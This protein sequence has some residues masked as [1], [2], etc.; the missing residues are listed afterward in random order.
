MDEN[1]LPPDA[2]LLARGIARLLADLG[3]GSLTEFTL[4]TGRRMDLM[5]LDRRGRL[6]GVEIKRSLQD[7]RADRK[8]PEYL[9]YCDGFYFAVPP[10]FPVEVLPGE[11]GLILADAWGAEIVRP[12]PEPAGRIAP[13]RRRELTLRFALGAAQRLRRLEDPAAFPAAAGR[14]GP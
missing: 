2:Q 6:V 1:P 11:P 8:W 7:F 10:G 4:R 5:G 12:A 3:Y 14:T 13:A 9:D